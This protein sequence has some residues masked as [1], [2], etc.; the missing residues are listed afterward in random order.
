MPNIL[1]WNSRANNP[2]VAAAIFLAALCVA[3]AAFADPPSG[4]LTTGPIHDWFQSLEVPGT[5][6]SCCSE[7]DCRPVD[8]RLADKGYEV[9]IENEWRAVPEDRVL[10]GKTNPTGRG[11]LCRMPYSG[12]I[13]CFVPGWEA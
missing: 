3:V 7:A 10:H 4:A 11:I 9:F 13:L 6:T 2:L 5:N 12:V 1:G 8:Y